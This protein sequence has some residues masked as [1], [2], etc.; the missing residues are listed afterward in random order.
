MIQGGGPPQETGGPSC[1]A[2]QKLEQAVEEQ[3]DLLAE[4]EKVADELQRILDDLEGST[5]VKRLKAAS[6]AQSGIATGL[7]RGLSASFGLRGDGV[8]DRARRLWKDLAEREVAHSET[9]YFIRE[10]LAAYSARVQDAEF[11]TVL[12]EMRTTQVVTSLRGIAATVEENL[13]GQ[14]IAHAEFWADTLDRWAE[15]LVGPG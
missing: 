9:V 13:S 11:I 2:G 10:D 6:R 5:F 12:K 7:H 1:P 3:E 8:D 14:S 4:F 15:Q